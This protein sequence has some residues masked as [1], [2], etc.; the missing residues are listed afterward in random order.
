MLYD[1]NMIVANRMSLAESE[2]GQVA[3]SK[4]SF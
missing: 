4:N 2:D 3:L 1:Y